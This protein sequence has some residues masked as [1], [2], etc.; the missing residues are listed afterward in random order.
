M[1]KRKTKLGT[2]LFWGFFGT[3][4]L[5]CATGY[6][7]YYTSLIDFTEFPCLLILD[8]TTGVLASMILGILISRAVKRPIGD[9]TGAVKALVRGELDAEI[10]VASKDETGRLAEIIDKDVRGLLKENRRQKELQQKREGYRE[11]QLGRVFSNLNKLAEGDLNCDMAVDEPDEDTRQIHDM[12][13][14][15]SDSLYRSF[16]GIKGYIDEISRVLGE[17][18]EGNF[19]VSIACDFKGDFEGLKKSI[20]RIIDRTNGLLLRIQTAAEEVSAVSRQV[21][22]SNRRIS[23]S[24]GEQ[25]SSIEQLSASITQIAQQVR[26]NAQDASKSAKLAASAKDDAVAGDEKMKKMLESMDEINASS[27]SISKIIKVIDEIAFQTN[28]LALN[29]AIEA[30]RAGTHGKGFAVVADEVRSL[31]AKSAEAAKETA[32]LIEDSVKRIEAGTAIAKE[33]AEALASIVRE[34]EES[35]ALLEGIAQSANEQ[36]TG[37]AQINK[38]IELLTQAVQTN[39]AETQQSAAASAELSNQAEALKGLVVKT[40]LKKLDTGET[41]R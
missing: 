14:S 38:G 8:T 3:G 25:A 24:V 4:A 15:I 2:K 16:G 7:L 18:A 19:D 33:T 6:F 31:A 5:A 10:R 13:C 11:I 32:V 9:I 37:I 41:A 29:A 12:Y 36:A 1:K 22:E 23:E 21:S 17:L 35:L 27:E 40:K 30:A 20:D 26:Q 34:S 28:I 39:S